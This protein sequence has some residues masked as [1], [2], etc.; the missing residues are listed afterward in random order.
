MFDQETPANVLEVI[1]NNRKNAELTS[2]P[3]TGVPV[4]E[5]DV[6]PELFQRLL[7]ERS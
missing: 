4:V 3:F 7:N 6:D 2:D 1:A 5:E